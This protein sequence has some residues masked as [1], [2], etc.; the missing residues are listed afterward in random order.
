MK[1]PSSAKKRLEFRAGVPEDAAE[2]A[3]LHSA[4]A[5]HL[6][7]RYGK[8][9]WS[10]RISEKGVLYA[11]R[12]S[13][14]VVATDG[15]A[16]LAT[17]CL[18]RKK[19]WAIDTSYFTK[20]EKPLYLLAM[21]V[22][23]ARQGQGIGRKCLEE[24]ERIAR[25]SPADAIRLDAY[26]AKAGGVPFYQRCGYTETG[27]ASYRNVPLVYYELLLTK[28][29]GSTRVLDVARRGRNVTR[30]SET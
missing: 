7:G 5:D 27:R 11:M 2:L 14:V 22:V 29:P 30:K 18:A 26:D 21:A 23:P 20:C 16:I 3:A 19:P 25:K 10:S 6:S 24:A 8:G 9:A 4:V 28:I 13:Q 1:S 17:F 12:H 15:A